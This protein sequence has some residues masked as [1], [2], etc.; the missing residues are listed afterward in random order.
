DVTPMSWPVGMGSDFEG[1]YDL[2]RNRLVQAST[3]ARGETAFTTTSVEGID[4]PALGKLLSA[5]GI[6]H[7]N[8]EAALA[9]AGYAPFDETAYR[10]GD[11]TPVYFG[12]ALRDFGV[13][14]L[15]DAIA[16]HAPP[17]RP[18]PA[19]P[20]PVDPDDDTVTGF[21]FKVQANMNPQH[22]DRIAFMRL[23]SGKFTRGMKLTPTGSG[24]A[25]AV[26][27]PI[28]FFAQSREVADEAYPG[29]IIGIPN[30]GTL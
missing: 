28:L 16:T 7:L 20:R 2:A 23:C 10:N 17:P 21:I 8:D 29:D 9:V 25:M 24:K 27:S 6:A 19:E 30:H 15:I 26:H 3:N 4:D 12:S 22:R 18:Q 11:L 14:E 1:V 5:D 13:L